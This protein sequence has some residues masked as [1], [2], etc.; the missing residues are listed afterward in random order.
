M[1]SPLELLENK[2]NQI[3][4]EYY[5]VF[6]LESSRTKKNYINKRKKFDENK[7]E[8]LRRIKRSMNE[9]QEIIHFIQEIKTME[10]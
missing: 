9:Y 3:T 8:D 2:L 1:K 5:R 6:A 7:N 10:L 4:Q